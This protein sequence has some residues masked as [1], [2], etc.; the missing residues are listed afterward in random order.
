M[1]H[2]DGAKYYEREE[3][4]FV[5]SAMNRPHGY[6]NA[7]TQGSWKLIGVPSVIFINT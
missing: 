3:H 1:K 5:V 2:N 6:K 4:P 7:W